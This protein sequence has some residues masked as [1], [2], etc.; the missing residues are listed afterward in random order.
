MV[1]TETVV[2][3]NEFLVKPIHLAVRFWMMP[4]YKSYIDAQLLHEGL[5]H[6]WCDLRTRSDRPL[7]SSRLN[8]QKTKRIKQ[9]ASETQSTATSMVV[10]PLD[11][12]RYVMKSTERWVQGPWGMSRDWSLPAGNCLGVLDWAHR[13]GRHK[14]LHISMETWIP[15]MISQ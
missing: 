4:R 3:P 15:I 1:T 11:S 14:V 8:R 5:P 12:E 13:M 10:L 9:K 2:V 7:S 6:M